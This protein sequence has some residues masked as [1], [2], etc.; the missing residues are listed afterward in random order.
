[1]VY[2]YT[3]SLFF[4]KSCVVFLVLGLWAWRLDTS[5]HKS[6]VKKQ[7]VDTL[8]REDSMF[9]IYLQY[10]YIYCNIIQYNTIQYNTNI[11]IYTYTIVFYIIQHDIYIYIY[12]INRLYFIYY[13][14][15]IH[16]SSLP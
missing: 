10:I 3:L 11:Y 7:S 13:M 12:H 1:M 5:S 2:T 14:W 16:S 9:M 15:L 6:Q 8:A 4:F